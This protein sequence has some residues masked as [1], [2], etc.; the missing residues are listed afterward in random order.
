MTEGNKDR[1][2]RTCDSHTPFTLASHR[3]NE[4]HVGASCFCQSVVNETFNT[5]LRLLKSGVYPYPEEIEKE[6]VSIRGV[7]KRRG[8]K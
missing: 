7:R 1:F 8:I 6:R 4:A 2:I 5:P 3:T